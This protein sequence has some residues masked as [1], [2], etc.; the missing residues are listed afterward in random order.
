MNNNIVTG[1]TYFMTFSP[2]AYVT[3]EQLATFLYRYAQYKGM[4]TTLSTSIDEILGGTYVN[5]W[6][7]DGFAWAVDRGII[8]GIESTGANGQIQ[9][10]LNP[11]G[12]AT[13]AQLARM[14]HRYLGG[15]TE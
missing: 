5:S 7:K 11:Q 6:A 3:R 2:E 14:L 1:D 9:Y 4:D 15:T 8:R 13:R 10:D 12:G